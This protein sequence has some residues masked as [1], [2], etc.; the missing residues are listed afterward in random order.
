MRGILHPRYAR[1][2]SRIS[3]HIGAVSCSPP[4]NSLYTAVVDNDLIHTLI[5]YRWLILIPLSFWESTL[6]AFVAGMLASA[7]YF[8]IYSLAAF[9]FL[10]DIALDLTYYALGRYAGKLQIVHRMLKKI[11]I[12]DETMESVRNTWNSRPMRTMFI[13]KLSYGLAQA[14]IIAA[15]TVRMSLK[16]FVAWGALAA[17]TQYGILLFLGYYFG[18]SSGGEIISIINNIQYVLLG[19]SVV[20]VTYYGIA[21]YL[22]SKMLESNDESL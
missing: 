14:F 2:D 16:K 22:R 13:G 8:S 21:L 15:G 18:E 10:R 19:G 1:S 17:A 11:H 6:V 9:F 4:I 5:D 3:L 20:I 12:T 7:G